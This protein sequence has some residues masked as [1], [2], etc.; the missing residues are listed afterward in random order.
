MD[1]ITSFGTWLK[2]RRKALDLTQEELARRL[3]C[4]TVTLQKIELDERRPSKEIAARLAEALEIPPA[5]RPPFL[6]VARGE[7]PLEHLPGTATLPA[8][9]PPAPPT[10]TVTWLFTDLENSTQLWERHPQAMPAALAC[11]DACS[12]MPSRPTAAA[13]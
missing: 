7:L 13:S 11:H 5:E 2:Q 9:P 3:G 8:V 1:E 4:A 12:A 6:G 10:G